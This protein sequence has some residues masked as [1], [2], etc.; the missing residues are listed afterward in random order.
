M[1]CVNASC[2]IASTA[3]ARKSLST[4]SRLRLPLCDDICYSNSGE[5]RLYSLDEI[6]LPVHPRCKCY[7]LPVFEE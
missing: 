4:L 7:T 6:V 3:S 2:P 1:I 5:R